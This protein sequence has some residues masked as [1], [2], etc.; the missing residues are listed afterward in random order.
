MQS[1]DYI[2]EKCRVAVISLAWGTESLQERLSDSYISA[3]ER[4]KAE[5]LPPEMR[6]D[7]ESVVYELTK[8]KPT[9]DEGSL[10][11]SVAQLD[12]DTANELIERIVGLFETVC[13]LLG[14][15][16]DCPDE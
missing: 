16:E 1:L 2:R 15:E 13:R 7:F 5:E 14:P 11:A 12:D 9:S 3:L 8:I 4:L 6:D 10:A